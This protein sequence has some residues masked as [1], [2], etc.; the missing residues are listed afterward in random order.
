MSV[1]RIAILSAAIVASLV[2]GP[3]QA[4]TVQGTIKYEGAVPT[5]KVVDMAA[6]PTC[7]AKH[8]TPPK[9]EMLVLG[10][11][12][13]L[14]NVFVRVKSGLAA[15]DYPVRTEKAVI[16]QVGCRYVPH[17]VGVMVGQKFKFLNSD[18]IMHNVHAL[19]KVN[20][21]FNMAMPAS[22]TEAEHEFTTE[23]WMFQIKCD[24]HPW[25]NAY[26]AVMTHP[27]FDTTGDDG[28]FSIPN[29]P[30]GSYEI[31]AWHE[32]LGTKTGKVTVTADGAQTIDF[33]MSPPAK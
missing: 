30:A 14:A 18:G 21:Q 12:N 24:V 22:R 8:K 19:P 29:V 16:D 3:A 27:F 20:K 5:L 11:G 13:A 28:K 4:G 32:K 1:R 2:L 9:S 26:V 31:E 15:G 6:E 17:V 10:A 33:T 23:E 25:M 7:A